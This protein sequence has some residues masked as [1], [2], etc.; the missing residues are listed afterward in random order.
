MASTPGG[1]VS[2]SALAVFMLMTSS[3]LVGRKTGQIG[4][5]G[6]LQDTSGIDACLLI[7]VRQINPITH[8][9]ARND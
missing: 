1:M 3:N 7:D 8:Q 5:F 2:P 9:T 6:T 4:R